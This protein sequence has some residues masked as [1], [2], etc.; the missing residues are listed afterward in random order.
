[1]ADYRA[2]F[3]AELRD[4]HTSFLD[5]QRGD[6][7]RVY[8]LHSAALHGRPVSLLLHFGDDLVGIEARGFQTEW[9]E[10]HFAMGDV[11]LA[12]L[13]A[14]A[15]HPE[16]I[17]LARG[18][19]FRPLLDTSVEEI[20]ARG[21][22]VNN[23]V[24][25]VNTTGKF[26]GF[27]GAGVLIGVIDTGIDIHHPVFLKP[28]STNTTRILRI[29]DMG[30]A[31]HDG[32]GSP[33]VSLLQ[34]S[35]TY[36]VEY[37]EQMINDVLQKKAGAKPVKHKDCY[38]HGTYAA[39]IAAGDGR[40][41]RLKR[42]WEFVGVAPEADLIVV[43]FFFPEQEPP[44][45]EQH[46]FVDA[47]TYIER[48]AKTKLNDRPL[49]ISASLGENL[50]THDGL[51]A[52][53]HLLETRYLGATR[54]AFVA[55]AGNDGKC[56][57]HG[58]IVIPAGGKVDVPF[59]LYDERLGVD[60]DKRRC[61]SRPNAEPEIKIEFWYRAPTSAVPVT[62][63]LHPPKGPAKDGPP[64]SGTAS[65][66]YAGKYKF[67]ISHDAETAPRPRPPPG[68]QVTRNVL[69]I[70]FS[71]AEKTVG[72]KKEKN[73]YSPGKFTLHLEGPANTTVHAY[74][75][76]FYPDHG[77]RIGHDIAGTVK[78]PDWMKRLDRASLS[79]AVTVPDSETINSPASSPGAV[80]VAGYNDDTGQLWPQ[81]SQGPLTDYSGLGAYA[82][83]PDVAAPGED[84]MAANADGSFLSSQLAKVA[85]QS[86][87]TASGTSAAV[88]HVSGVAALMF[89]KKP[90]LAQADLVTHLKG[91]ARATP[92]KDQFGDGKVDAKASR[93]AV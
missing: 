64:L 15:S 40:A 7:G 57:Q 1:M 83:K 67:M 6:R 36:G 56:R 59:T 4:I 76:Q 55:A 28:N 41:A 88:P 9:V 38:G 42:R 90:N 65:G 78:E 45:D 37:T 79:A 8:P 61:D 21:P 24:W 48:T 63:T 72:G 14:V 54:K 73:S 11:D 91:K 3:D 13:E 85:G 44:V 58:V 69:R 53:D 29:W 89:E 71:V 31:P 30:I 74:A 2:K 68:T 27:R 84:I 17:Q 82:A 39:S 10:G 50:G 51:E 93:D 32:I 22:D 87:V 86:Y 52:W 77:I 49:V 26:D 81:S 33:D 35:V 5:I 47:F 19:G 20:N 23:A 70:K 18:R 75:N 12:D 16:V 60:H 25:T 62:S 34:G 92:P 46:R 80:A 43:K 66:T